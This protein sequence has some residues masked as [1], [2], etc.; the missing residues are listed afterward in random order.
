MLARETEIE[1]RKQ[2]PN[3]VRE[4]LNVLC[5]YEIESRELDIHFLLVHSRTLAEA[6]DELL[7]SGVR[8]IPKHSGEV[9]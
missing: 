3:L 5:A 6:C 9:A 7:S 4:Q 8:R 2:L 1:M